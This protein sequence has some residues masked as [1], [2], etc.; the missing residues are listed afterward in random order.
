[1]TQKYN[2]HNK[3]GG[4]FVVEA[5]NRRNSHSLRGDLIWTIAKGGW[6]RE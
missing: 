3:T 2:L 5:E 1:M 4:N 6:K